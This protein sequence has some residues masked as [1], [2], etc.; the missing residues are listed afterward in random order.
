MTKHAALAL[1]PLAFLIL[2]GCSGDD[3]VKPVVNPLPANNSPN[4]AL[5]RLEA[6]LETQSA[7]GYRDLLTADYRFLFSS[8]T[9][10]NLVVY[11]GT[12]WG[13][14]L[15]DLSM[16]N[17]FDAAT[18][19]VVTFGAVTIVDDSTH[20]DSTAWYRVAQISSASAEITVPDG[21]G[22]FVTYNPDARQ[23]LALVRGDA[24]LL[25]AGVPADSTH[26]YVRQWSDLA[27]PVS[28]RSKPLPA[29]AI[30]LPANAVTWGRLRATFGP[31][32][33]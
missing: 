13:R 16:Q 27:S 20:A 15:D 21:S 10:P 18:T 5:A 30:P 1:P 33:F 11:Y 23:D 9:D 22:G 8:Q 4:G 12:S 7:T 31:P 32:T 14:T 19:V 28:A 6:S 29:I 24:A 3:P 25:P 26:W 2:A 17:M